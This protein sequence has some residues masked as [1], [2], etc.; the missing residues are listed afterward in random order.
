[1]WRCCMGFFADCVQFN[2]RLQISGEGRIFSHGAHLYSWMP[3][4]NGAV[5][6]TEPAAG[7]R[8]QHWLALLGG[9]AFL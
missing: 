6:K 4:Q 2:V 8:N 3:K 1:M 5:G 9:E 7:W